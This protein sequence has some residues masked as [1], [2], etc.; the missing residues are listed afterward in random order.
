M[1]APNMYICWEWPTTICKL[2]EQLFGSKVDTEMKF[3][4]DKRLGD[5]NQPSRAC[6]YK[7][8]TPGEKKKIYKSLKESQVYV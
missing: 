7:L 5:N 6:I 8:T 4:S 3:L 1:C 2:L